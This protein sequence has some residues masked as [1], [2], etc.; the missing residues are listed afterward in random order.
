M[1]GVTRKSPAELSPAWPDA[2]SK[3]R[4]GEVITELST[5][6]RN[7]GRIRDLADVPH[8]YPTWSDAVWNAALDE[9]AERQQ[10]LI[11]RR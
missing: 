4:A 7:G 9:Q 3:D 5:V 11:G 10:T 2:P 6:L 1:V 8:A